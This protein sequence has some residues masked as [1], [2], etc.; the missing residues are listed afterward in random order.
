MYGKSNINM[1]EYIIWKGSDVMIYTD[2]DRKDDFQW[3]LD[4][5]ELLYNQYGISYLVI[6]NKNILGSYAQY[7]V[8]VRETS[9]TIEL[10]KFIVQLCNGDESGYTNYIASNEVGVI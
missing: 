8:A 2:V 5:Y 1:I 9:K 7:G 10:G 4:N 3:F 6:Q